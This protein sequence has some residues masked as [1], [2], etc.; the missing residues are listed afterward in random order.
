MVMK[1]MERV[2][3]VLTA[4]TVL[5]YLG[6]HLADR[7]QAEGMEPAPAETAAPETAEETCPETEPE[8]DLREDAC[9]EVGTQIRAGCAFA[10]DV[11][12]R[13][14]LYSSVPA[15]QQLYPASLTKLF[16]AYVALQYLPPDTV[17]TAGWELGMLQPGSSTAYIPMGS[18][19]TVEML[20][21]AMLL[22]SGNDAAY[23]LAAAAGRLIGGKQ[24]MGAKR[25]VALFVEEMN[26]MGGELGLANSHFENPD[27]YHHENHY[28]CAGDLATIGELALS[29]DVIAKYARMQQDGVRFAS[30]ETIAWYNNNRLLNPESA[31][32]CEQAVG[33]KTGYTTEAGYCLLAAFEAGERQYLVGILD[34]DT[35]LSRY[36]D[37][38]ALFRAANNPEGE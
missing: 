35:T 4:L 29:S 23:I 11:A 2:L 7:A 10:Y 15:T 31:W 25:A 30:G 28:S 33:L 21:E 14:M 1:R 20:V 19:L 12:Q 13:K 36:S 38:V 22:P 37:A 24:D 18:R 6:G 27:G 8:P 34:A 3:L 9:R 16:S 32:Y 5:L 26:R 17:V